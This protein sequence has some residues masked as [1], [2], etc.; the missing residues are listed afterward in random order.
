VSLFFTGNS[1]PGKIVHNVLQA[2]DRCLFTRAFEGWPAD[3]VRKIRV[4]K[5]VPLLYPFL[6]V[7]I[8]SLDVLLGNMPEASP[9]FMVD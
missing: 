7:L 2:H 6:K 5:W 8:G 3:F 9:A 1:F 4:I